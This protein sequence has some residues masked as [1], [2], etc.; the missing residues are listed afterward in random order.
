MR[1]RISRLLAVSQ[2][3]LLLA[4]LLVPALAN[5]EEPPIL[6]AT[7]S[8]TAVTITGAN[9]GADSVVDVTT[10]DPSG[11]PIDVS[12][13]Q[14]DASG[15]FSYS[16][17]LTSVDVGTYSVSAQGPGASAS[18]TFDGAAAPTPDPTPTDPPTEPSPTDPPTEPQPTDPPATQPEPTDPAEPTP[19]PEPT[20]HYIVTFMSGSTASERAAA[21]AAVDAI[22]GDR[23]PALSLQSI[24][25]PAATAAGAIQDLLA[26]PAVL[27]VEA[28]RVRDAG[29][30]PSD[31]EYASQWSLPRIGWDL[32][33][34][35]I[36]PVGTATVAVLDTGVDGSHPDLAGQLVAGTSILDGSDGTSDPNGHGTAM[37]GI[38]AA[39]HGQR[40]GHRGR[41]LRRRPASCRS[42]SSA[43]TAPART[44]TSS[45]G[46]VWAVDHGA[47]VILMAFSN[48]GYSAVAAGGHRLRL[49]QRRRPRRRDRQR[50]LV[51]PR[52]SRP[53]T[54][55]SSA[56]PTPTRTT[57]STGLS[58]YG[59]GRLPR[60]ARRRTSSRPPLAA[61]TPAIT[62]TSASAAASW[63]ARPPLRANDS[64][65]ATAS[66]SDRLAAQRRRRRHAGPDRQRP[67]QPGPR[68]R[69]HLDD[70]APARRRGAGGRPVRRA[71]CRREQVHDDY[72]RWDGR[73]VRSIHKLGCKFAGTKS[74]PMCCYVLGGA[75]QQRSWQASRHSQCRVDIYVDPATWA[76]LP[77]P[78]TGSTPRATSAWATTPSRSRS[79]SRHRTSLPSMTSR[80]PKAVPPARRRSPSTSRGPIHLA[81]RPSPTPRPPAAARPAGAAPERLTTSRPPGLRPSRRASRRRPSR[82]MSARTPPSSR[83]RRS[84]SPFQPHECDEQRQRRHGHDHQRRHGTRPHDRRHHR[85]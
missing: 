28:D 18:A 72:V 78:C 27:F 53:A 26:S 13:A 74:E 25:L 66:S 61:A 41:R 32:A 49:G 24:G 58:N 64:G 5:A 22:P 6:G 71:V 7:R 52:P 31:T 21:L 42:R 37:A 8:G 30:T 75:G 57:P 2:A 69:R 51:A 81:L 65:V 43:P 73:G 3:L 77:T 11:N 1:A 20:L 38:V 76:G 68:P 33:Y 54:A 15:G 16:F 63:P 85:R 48:P 56:S 29:A 44:A 34:G 19:A 59:A 39:A 35:S 47:D 12:S 10:S 14:V 79:P 46:V 17:A 23:I 82:S 80:R 9:F 55:A 67:A 60:R 70:S 40:P 36:A 45:Q 4:S 62:G 84:R 83:T 50:R